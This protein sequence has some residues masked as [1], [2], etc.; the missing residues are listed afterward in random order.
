MESS[1]WVPDAGCST[2]GTDALPS[3]CRPPHNPACPHPLLSHFA[4]SVSYSP[5]GKATRGRGSAQSTAAGITT[6]QS[7]QRAAA[8]MAGGGRD[9]PLEGPSTIPAGRAKG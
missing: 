6:P 1:P 3:R 8:G 9:V 5:L 4:L 7:R 2:L